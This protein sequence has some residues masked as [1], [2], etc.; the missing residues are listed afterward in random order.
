MMH[1]ISTIRRWWFGVSADDPWFTYTLQSGEQLR[2][3]PDD[4]QDRFDGD[5]PDWSKLIEK[6]TGDMEA[7]VK[8]AGVSRGVFILS[9]NTTDAEAL[10]VL[11]SYLEWLTRAI[12]K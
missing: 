9:A 8:L 7:R 3:D 4:I 12:Q 6:I 1:F 5:Y 11:A 10:Q 2:L